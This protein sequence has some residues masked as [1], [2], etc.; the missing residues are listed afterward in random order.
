M[1]FDEIISDNPKVF[2]GRRRTRQDNLK[3]KNSSQL[4]AFLNSNEEI[5]K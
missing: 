4:S 3:T 1:G 2:S 5:P